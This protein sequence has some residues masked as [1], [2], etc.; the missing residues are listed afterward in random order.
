[1]IMKFSTQH[2]V[3]AQSNI[4][5]GREEG[6]EQPP[7]LEIRQRQDRRRVDVDTL[8]ISNITTQQVTRLECQDCSQAEKDDEIHFR[9]LNS[10]HCVICSCS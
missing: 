10:L 3:T 2:P 1:M 5:R 4:N 7:K 8:L 9:I 6:G